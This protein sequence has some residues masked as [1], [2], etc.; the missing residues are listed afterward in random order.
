[1]RY[2]PFF[3]DKDFANYE[4]GNTPYCIVKTTEEVIAKLEKPSKQIF[5]WFEKNTLKANPQELLS[6]LIYTMP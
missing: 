6:K 1:M 2:V 5:E 4:G 3:N